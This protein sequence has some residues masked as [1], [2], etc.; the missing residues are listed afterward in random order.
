M[1]L[2]VHHIIHWEDGG[3]TDVWNLVCLCPRHHRAHHR[4]ELGITGDANTPGGLRFTDRYG[5]QLSGASRAR[6]PTPDDVPDVAP[7]PG[8]TGERLDPTAITFT[9]RHTPAA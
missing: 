6:P 7:C 1:W 2:E 8:P 9:R 3:P 5:E 4:G